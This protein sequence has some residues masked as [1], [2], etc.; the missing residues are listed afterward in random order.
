LRG[1]STADID[2]PVTGDAAAIL[3]PADNYG[4]KMSFERL[5]P[6]G[7]IL[8]VVFGIFYVRDRMSGGYR[9]ERLVASDEKAE[10]TA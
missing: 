7:I 1:V 2:S 5:A 3:N 9:A 4:G 10:A 8:I 6:F